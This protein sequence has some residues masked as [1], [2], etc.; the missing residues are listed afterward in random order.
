MNSRHKELGKG[1]HARAIRPLMLPMT[2]QFIIVMIGTAINDRLQRKL[3]YVEE[4]RRILREK[5]DAVRP[6]TTLAWFRQLAAR[7]YDSSDV[8]RGR[9]RH[10]NQPYHG[11]EHPGRGWHRAAAGAGEVSHVEAV[12]EGALGFALWCDLV[13]S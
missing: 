6:A 9:T 4:E 13:G 7:K 10:R 2:L 3:D 5:L 12:H 1:C 11:R 8:R